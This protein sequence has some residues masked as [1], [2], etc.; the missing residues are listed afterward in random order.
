MEGPSSRVQAYWWHGSHTRRSLGSCPILTQIFMERLELKVLASRHSF[1]L[2]ALQ[3]LEAT[4]PLLCCVQLLLRAF[5]ATLPSRILIQ[6]AFLLYDRLPAA[7]AR[8]RQTLR[9]PWRGVPGACSRGTEHLAS[10]DANHRLLLLGR[11]WAG[12]YAGS[13]D[14]RLTGRGPPALETGQILRGIVRVLVS[15]GIRRRV[16]IALPAAKLQRNATTRCFS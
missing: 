10:L 6:G 15:P 13:S 16:S 7:K 4:S 14:G 11:F 1:F 5:T 3:R 9:S 12:H 2:S 8:R